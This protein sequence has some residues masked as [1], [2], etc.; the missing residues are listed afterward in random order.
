[1]VKLQQELRYL[2]MARH[3]FPPNF[4]WNAVINYSQETKDKDKD[5]DEDEEADEDQDEDKVS[6]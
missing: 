5:T 6:S 4:T 3:Y 2:I 1:M